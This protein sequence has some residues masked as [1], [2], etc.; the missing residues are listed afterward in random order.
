MGQDYTLVI[1][2]QLSISLCVFSLKTY[3]NYMRNCCIVLW[4]QESLS[5]TTVKDEFIQN[6]HCTHFSR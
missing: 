3:V 4:A 6:R 1:A 5:F 2:A